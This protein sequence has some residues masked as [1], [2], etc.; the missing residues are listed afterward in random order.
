MGDPLRHFSGGDAHNPLAFVSNA[1]L[2]RMVGHSLS[3]NVGLHSSNRQRASHIVLAL[4]AAAA[5]REVLRWAKEHG[6]PGGQQ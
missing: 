3:K 6:C 5:A 1:I 2:G 4:A